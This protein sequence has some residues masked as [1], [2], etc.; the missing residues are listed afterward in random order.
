MLDKFITSELSSVRSWSLISEQKNKNENEDKNKVFSNHKQN[1][2]DEKNNKEN[3]DIKN[4]SAIENSMNDN[5]Q[6]YDENKQNLDSSLVENHLKNI[7]KM[8]NYK[9]FSSIF[10]LNINLYYFLSYL[11]K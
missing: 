11:M 10:N 5:Y 2:Y 7:N 6:E 4:R 3:N 8:S 1:K 9:A